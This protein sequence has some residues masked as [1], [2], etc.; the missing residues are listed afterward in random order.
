MIKEIWENA[1]FYFWNA[2]S[3]VAICIDNAEGRTVI[4]F[5]GNLAI[6]TG[7][8]KIFDGNFG[9]WCE[10]DF[11]TVVR[12]IDGIVSTVMK[13]ELA[14]AELQKELDEITEIKSDIMQF[15]GEAFTLD[16]IAIVNA[17]E[18][19]LYGCFLTVRTAWKP[20][21]NSVVIVG[22]DMNKYAKEHAVD[23]QKWAE[24]K[25]SKIHFDVFRDMVG[26]PVGVI[27]SW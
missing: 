24:S 14:C 1:K 12:A 21:K 18:K 5:D 2:T 10:C 3:E 20:S 16:D 27:A 15:A 25:G 11:V 9:E 6:H 13:D 23:L 8:Y 22:P 4:F 7:D 17:V 19:H 26:F